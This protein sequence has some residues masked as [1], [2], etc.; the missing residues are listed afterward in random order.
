MHLVTV[1]R[2]LGGEH[3]AQ[4]G[5]V[6]DDENLLFFRQHHGFAECAPEP[7]STEP[8]AVSASSPMR[9]SDV[10]TEEL[11]YPDQRSTWSGASHNQGFGGLTCVGRSAAW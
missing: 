11:G 8:R 4:V 1:A 6:V 10:R 9:K 2:E 5:L 3:A 7:V